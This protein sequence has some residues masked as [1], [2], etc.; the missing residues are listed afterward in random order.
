[1]PLLSRCT[2]RS[3]FSKWLNVTTLSLPP[4]NTTP[5]MQFSNRFPV[6]IVPLN[7]SSRYTACTEGQPSADPSVL[8]MFLKLSNATG[9]REAWRR[10]AGALQRNSHVAG[11]YVA[12]LDPRAPGVP[13]QQ[14]KRHNTQRNTT[15]SGRV[16]VEQQKAGRAGVRTMHH[17][18]KP[19]S[20]VCQTCF[21]Q[22]RC[23]CRCRACRCVARD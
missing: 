22:T 10:N 8:R 23:C 3:L 14:V 7:W 20:T 21:Q 16:T 19:H 5:V 1:M 11:Y 4:P 6:T 15:H 2:A 18:L 9:V 12:S 13:A 17:C